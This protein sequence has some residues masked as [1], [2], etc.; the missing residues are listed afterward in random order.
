[1]ASKF[2]KVIFNMRFYRFAHCVELDI[3]NG[4]LQNGVSEKGFFSVLFCF[5][6]FSSVLLSFH[7]SVLPVS[8]RM[9]SSNW[10]IIF[11]KKNGMVSETH[12]TFYF[13]D[14]NFYFFTPKMAQNG[15]KIGFLK[16]LKKFI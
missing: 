12:M 4:D 7:L 2:C 1:M 8:A 10:M 6:F 14:L 15:P 13:R 9:I 3:Q 5:L 16:L 11:L